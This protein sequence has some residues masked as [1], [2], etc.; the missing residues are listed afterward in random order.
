MYLNLQ[1]GYYKRNNYS[2]VQ[3][4]ALAIEPKL[5]RPKPGTFLVSETEGQPPYKYN[6]KIIL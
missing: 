1:D 5:I 2:D 3:I 6:M 4:N